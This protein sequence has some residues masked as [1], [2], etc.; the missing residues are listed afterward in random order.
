MIPTNSEQ[1][2]RSPMQF[3]VVKS[4]IT[5]V[6]ESRIKYYCLIKGKRH[7]ILPRDIV[8]QGYVL[9]NVKRYRCP[10]LIMKA[11]TYPRANVILGYDKRETQHCYRSNTAFDEPYQPLCIADESAY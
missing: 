6:S 10:L 2:V 4:P 8:C 11:M 7:Q 5:L 9:L 3:Q 1:S